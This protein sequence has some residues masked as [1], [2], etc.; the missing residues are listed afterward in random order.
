MR[1][2]QKRDVQKRDVLRTPESYSR[3]LEIALAK[4][5]YELA[6]DLV[7]RATAAAVTSPTTWKRIRTIEIYLGVHVVFAKRRRG[8][9]PTRPT[10]ALAA[11]E[12]KLAD[13]RLT[14]P[15]LA[16]QYGMTREDLEKQVRTLKKFLAR[17]G[18]TLTTL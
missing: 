8:R 13:S 15:K 9:P 6:D 1:P 17:E 16:A 10:T 14:W 12:L 18:I 7:M 11:L 4:R 5:M 2:Y 3:P